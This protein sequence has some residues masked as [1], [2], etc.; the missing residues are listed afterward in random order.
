MSAIRLFEPGE[1]ANV[2]A[3]QAAERPAHREM[4][5]PR[6]TAPVRHP[7]ASSSSMRLFEPG[8]AVDVA[9]AQ[10]ASAPAERPAP[11]PAGPVPQDG[12][13]FS[14]QTMRLF[15]PGEATD[16]A[17]AQN[18]AQPARPVLARPR[19]AGPAREAAARDL[20]AWAYPSELGEPPRG[21]TGGPAAG[22]PTAPPDYVDPLL[23]ELPREKRGPFSVSIAA[24]A[25]VIALVIAR[26]S[27]MA[28][29]LE[30]SP[31]PVDPGVF[32]ALQVPQPEP[33]PAKPPIQAPVHPKEARSAPEPEPQRQ[34]A[35]PLTPPPVPKQLPPQ[36]PLP[37]PTRMGEIVPVPH[38]PVP[39]TVP[40]EEQKTGK[41]GAP[42]EKAPPPEPIGSP[43]GTN[44]TN[45][46]AG[47]LTGPGSPSAGDDDPSRDSGLIREKFLGGLD[48]RS[49]RSGRAKQ[50]SSESE[51][52]GARRGIDF[53]VPGGDLGDFSFEDKDYDWNDY[54]SQMYY[55]ILRAWY[56]RLYL[57]TGN[58]ERYSYLKGGRAL[59]GKVLIRFVIERSGAVSS[60]EVLEASVMPPLDESARG[61]LKEVILPRLPADFPKEREAVTGRFIM[62]ID[63]V[64]LFKQELAWG[65]RQGEF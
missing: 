46:G 50:G 18:A 20:G 17:A 9:F 52:G 1:A 15:E 14:L 49:H 40:P 43:S 53:R 48:I 8:E 39:G 27:W 24:H 21:S 34:E 47:A 37:E 32:V 5:G 64:G 12:G 4:P 23:P 2:A 10:A 42:G 51:G 31:A 7:A 16:V 29:H 33:E 55:A 63:D 61:A 56:N 38:Y 59:R 62:D 13:A 19:N 22:A 60:I 28:A 58:F 35:P 11:K 54:H 44:E 6:P 26:T 25:L 30:A 3:A 36:A 65:K 57:M 41:A 45:G